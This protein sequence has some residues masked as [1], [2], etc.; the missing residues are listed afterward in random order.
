MRQTRR[1]QG[2]L[3]ELGK[4]VEFLPGLRVHRRCRARLQHPF[5]VPVEV[6]RFQIA[7]TEF[8]AH[9]GQGRFGPKRGGKAVGQ[10]ARHGNGVLCGEW[11]F[12]DA[13]QV[14]FHRGRVGVLVLV[15]AI[16]VGGQGLGG[17]ALQVH[18]GGRGFG[19]GAN[20][21]GAKQPVNVGQ[22]G[23]QHLG[24]FTLRQP[25]HHLHL[26]QTVLRMHV[27]QRTVHIDLVLGSDVRHPALV[28]TDADG[29]AEFCQR[30]CARALRLFGVE[31]PGGSGARG[32]D[33][34]DQQKGENFQVT[35]H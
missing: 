17:G 9:K 12:G 6:K 34:G 14:K 1:R 31:V 30:Q 21:E 27:T 13:Q 26:K 35:F 10:I 29:R 22:F 24:Q 25:A 20:D 7:G 8:V 19:M 11:S 16:Q 23:P 4:L 32:H 2:L 3:A 5:G 15:D 33:E 28:K 18:L